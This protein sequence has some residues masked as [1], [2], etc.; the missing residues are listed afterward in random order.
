MD[1]IERQMV[2]LNHKV[3]RLYQIVAQLSSQIGTLTSE[4]PQQASQE[5]DLWARGTQIVPHAADCQGLVGVAS[6]MEHKDILQDS[7]S[8]ETSDRYYSEPVLS[9]DIQILRLTAQ[10]TAAYNRIA[11]LEE[12]LI[13]CRIHP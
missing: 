2:D 5:T 12:Q 10:L 7:S 6:V 3:D 13:A 11:A 9:S 1:G 4:K 8:W